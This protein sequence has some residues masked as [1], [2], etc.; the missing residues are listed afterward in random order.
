MARIRS[1]QSEGRAGSGVPSAV[2]GGGGF[3]AKLADVAGSLSTRIYDLA[4]GAAQ[5]AGLLAGT[6]QV[7]A[8]ASGQYATGDP[9]AAKGYLQQHTDKGQEAIHGLDDNF[10]VKLANL[11]QAAPDNIRSGLGIYSGYRSNEH[12]AKLY[13]AALAKYGSEA[14]ARKWVA[15]PGHSQHNKGMAADVS[16]NGVSLSKAPKEVTDWIHQNAA[17]Y[18]LKFPLSNENWHIEDDSTRGGKGT[19][20]DPRPLAL[21]RDGT[22]FGEAYDRAASSAY[23]W[24]VQ[25]G[26][27]RELFQAQQDHPDDPYA[28]SAAKEEIRTRYLNDPALSD[29]LLR[30]AFQKGFEQTSDGYQRQTAIAYGAKLKAEEQSAFASGIDAMGV[31][32]ERQA[33]TYGANPDGDK[34][35]GDLVTSSQRSIDAAIDAGTVT[36]AAGETLKQDIAMRASQARIQGTYDALPTPESKQ[37]FAAGLVDRWKEQD[38]ALG[39]FNDAFMSDIQSLQRTL[40][41]NAASLTTAQKQANATRKAQLSTLMDDD[42]ASVLASGKGLDPSAGLSMAELEQYFTPAEIAKFRD[43]RNLS[44]DIHDATSGM[45][46]MTADDIAAL[47]E[48]MKPEPGQNGYADQQKIYDAASKKAAAILKARETDPLGQAA[49]AGIVEIQPIDSTDSGTITQ[50]LVARSQ[51]ARI[52]GGVL[53]TEMPLFTKAEVD[54]LKVQGKSTDPALFG[55]VMQQMDFLAN[56]DGLLS[57]KQTFGA[58]MMEDLQVWQSKMRYATQAEAQDWLKQHAD[59]QWQERVK[60]LVSSGEAKAR[61]VPF[62]D[63]VSELDPNWIA[64]IGAPIDDAS[65]RAMQNDYTMLVGQFYSR[66]GDIDAAQKQAIEA[67]KTVWGRTDALGGRGGRLMAYPPEKFYPAVASNQRY[68]KTEMQDLA[69]AAGVEIDQLSLVSDAKTEAAADRHEAP[70]YLISIVDPQTGFDEL[71]TDDAGRPLRHFF[72]PEAARKDAMAKAEQDR[73]DANGMAPMT[74]AERKAARQQGGTAAPLEINIPDN[75]PK[76]SFGRSRSPGH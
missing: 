57:V 58:P 48:D 71:L 28:F 17:A 42:I 41:S 15:P 53:G 39:A 24:R 6:Q 46:A 38:P 49:A 76:P 8:P 18:G 5:R 3:A 23:L 35:V 21:R 9:Y 27:S 13:S 74:P 29:P 66:I 25:S 63:I 47:V 4:Q 31:N 45:D 14:E 62:Q 56:S 65:K 16:Y 26:L 55:A 59:P 70:G 36:P 69:K 30:E 72:D 19:T 1:L 43:E 67:M 37:E 33:Y 20:I 2:T 12:Q 73:S 51:A 22:V 11:F 50:S 7:E 68:L 40:L 52:A 10:S 34:V 44:L 54:A 75:K 32:I 61:E 64:D 60:P